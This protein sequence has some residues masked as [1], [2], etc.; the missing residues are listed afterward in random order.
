MPKLS[1]TF[2]IP[3][4]FLLVPLPGFSRSPHKKIEHQ[5]SMGVEM[6]YYPDHNEGQNRKDGFDPPSYKPIEKPGSHV[7]PAGD[8]GR[9]LGTGWGGAKFQVYA[10]HSIKVPLLQG[11]SPLTKDNNI[12]FFFRVDAAP[13][14][15]NF[16]TKAVF[17]PL[18]FLNLQAGM[19]MGTGWHALGLNGM[20]LNKDGSGDPETRYT[21][22]IVTETWLGGTLQFDL[23]ALL[24]GKWNHVVALGN[25]RFKYAHFSEAGEDD[26]WQ[27]KSDA[28]ENFNGW[29]LLSTSLAGYQ[30]P[31]VLDTAGILVETEQN[32]GRNA[33]RSTMDSRGWGSDFVELRFGPLLNFTFD[34]H[35]S[36]TVLFHF[37]TMRVYSDKTV[38]NNWFRNRQYEST[39]LQFHAMALAYKY[40]F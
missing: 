27:W 17:T 36:L 13:V 21:A 8:K 3:L 31:L 30:M 37:R 4:V 6:V 10:A 19:N 26:P 5:S 20:G 12:H 24:P 25:C 38:H 32:L 23:A 9:P 18:A 29:K 7:L 40:R 1:Y 28:G 22:G 16:R 35:N 39:A 14:I 11:T 34:K 2:L 15:L 33:D